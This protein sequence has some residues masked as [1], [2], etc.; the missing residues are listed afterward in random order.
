MELQKQN[1]SWVEAYSQW[2][3]KYRFLSLL[4]ALAM[5]FVA[6]SGIKNLVFT[7]SYKVFFSEDNQFRASY[8]SM[9]KVYSNGD[10]ALIV[11]EP[12][13]RNVFSNDFLVA[14]EELTKD[15]WQVPSAYR[16]DS[17]T[18][19]QHT[20]AYED[21]LE[22]NSLIPD[23]KTISAQELARAKAVALAEPLLVNRIISKNADVTAVS[24]S[25]RLPDGND[26]IVAQV[27]SYV[28]QLRDKYEQKYPNIKI[29]LTGVAMMSNAFPE[30]SIQEM[31]TTTPTMFLIVLVFCFIV[32]RSFVGAFISFI[33][34]IFSIVTALGFAGHI[35]IKLTQ[36]SANVPIIVLTLAVADSIHILSTFFQQLRTGVE[37]KQAVI[38]SV[39]TNFS[40]VVIT[41]VTT[42]IGFLGLNFSDA[43]PFHDLGNMTAVGMIA[44]LVYSLLLLPCLLA[45][46][47]V[48][49]SKKA[50][51]EQQFMDF[52]SDWV[53]Y[54]RN[55]VLYGSVIFG[56]IMLA[57]TP[58]LTV[59]ENFVDNFAKGLE[60]RDDS[61]FTQAN[62]T[63]LFNME[64]S[65]DS[66]QEGGVTDPE[67]LRKV[68]QF[69]EWSRKQSG[70]LH[71]NS[72]TDTIKRLNRSMNA[73]DEL[74][75][76]L[77]SDRDLIA[78]YLLAYEMSLPLGLD[79][80]DQV[81]V[82][83]SSTKV[84]VT[85]D[86]LS[87]FEMQ[88]LKE[89]HEQWLINNAPQSMHTEAASA[90]LMY[91]YLMNT[92]IQGLLFGTALSFLI[93]TICLGLI[94]KSVKYALVSI[95]PNALPITMA[96]GMWSL[97]DGVV[98]IAA[99]TIATMTLGIVVDD[100]VHFVS[101]YL[102]AKR[103][104]RMKPEQAIRYAFSTVGKA[105]LST[106]LIFMIGFG[107]MMQSDFLMNAQM[108]IFTVMTVCFAVLLDFLLLPT[109]L[110]KLDSDKEADSEEF[111]QPEPLLKR[112]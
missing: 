3:V 56:L 62:L 97:I 24:V 100:T 57:M 111:V 22:I 102:R 71:V 94:F 16:V 101:K 81:N 38:E 4:I 23:A 63:G 45:I 72:I 107:S 59:D 14:V 6:A 67:F 95:L 2:V 112:I 46:L 65:L 9:Q 51:S 31:S 44:A 60:I 98:G 58:R 33:V 91:T 85:M 7:S 13:D 20:W 34:I 11:L 108:G 68:D 86:D 55:K 73:G 89:H 76:T 30:V 1:S 78:Q 15:A 8:E 96:F 99:A 25:V 48:K 47:P 41:S 12:K 77:P 87:T 92:N 52:F 35:G 10:S 32:L 5:F 29:H 42:A 103:E 82:A 27:A 69:V 53:L 109:L 110:L 93:I 36:V 19:F 83:K 40:P 79:V 37:K 21:G 43:P 84:T 39:R 75:Y 105:L 104:L 17:I 80:N 61:D 49:K 70:V 88:A 90:S 28:R 18:N 64:F 74:Y 54:H 26:L 50:S 106:S 66:A